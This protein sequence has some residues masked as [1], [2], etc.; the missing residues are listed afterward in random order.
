MRIP[1]HG[2]VLVCALSLFCTRPAI[3][4]SAGDQPAVT[5]VV[6]RAAA[7]SQPT[8]APARAITIERPEASR[9]SPL[10]WSLYSSTV[11][12]QGLDA[13]STFRALDAGAIETNPLV[14]WATANRPGFVALKLGIA[15]GTIY[16]AHALSRHHKIR[17]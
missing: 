8:A 15:A 6:V 4:E 3:A 1:W 16:S 9:W 12:V 10:L 14:S 2:P 5:A 11:V 17:A 7:E 13:A